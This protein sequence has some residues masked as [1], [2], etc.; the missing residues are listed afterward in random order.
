[1]ITE[2]PLIFKQSKEGCTSFKVTDI[3]VDK[4]KIS[5]V[6]PKHLLRTEKPKLPEVTEFQVVRHYTNL[7]VKNQHVDRNF[8]PLGSCTMKYN[9]KINDAIAL[10]TVAKI[11]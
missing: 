2:T 9:P 11:L 7:S 4:R 6:I 1:M 3:T 8:Y 5:D 10:N